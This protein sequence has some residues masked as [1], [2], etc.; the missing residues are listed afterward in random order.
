VTPETIKPRY[1]DKQWV[2]LAA[3][4]PSLTWDVVDAVTKYRHLLYV[5]GCNDAYR[6]LPD[7]N[8]HYACDAEWWHRHYARCATLPGEK[9]TQD[10]GAALQHKLRL[11]RGEY[12]DGFSTD[13]AKIYFGN[14]SGFQQLNLAYLMGARNFILVGYNM[15][16]VGEQ[17]HFFGDHPP[18]L[19]RTANYTQFVGPYTLIP[20]KH[21]KMQ[22]INTTPNTALTCFPRADL[23]KVLANIAANKP[24]V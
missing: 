10:E 6:M 21:L 8:V 19:R 16:A 15:T 11:V 5:H 12:E 3:T 7:L 17:R 22:I 4:G 14:N 13:P 20:W 2:V 1:T 24:P 9:W 18:G 23:E